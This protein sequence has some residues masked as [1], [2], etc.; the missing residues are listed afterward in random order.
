MYLLTIEFV[1]IN[2]CDMTIE[3]KLF[4]RKERAIEEM[5]EYKNKIYD[6]TVNR[7]N[8]KIIEEENIDDFSSIK[9]TEEGT[10]YFDKH[11]L[12]TVSKIECEDNEP[13]FSTQ[14]FLKS[15]IEM[16]MESYID[17]EPSEHKELIED[18]SR[19]AL[20]SDYLWDGFNSELLNIMRDDPRYVQLEKEYEEKVQPFE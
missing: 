3:T 18:I 14:D 17:G 16:I 12:I 9:F 7:R 11:L 5:N 1:E 8:M 6:Y 19:A 10:E 15:E 2:N 4:E 13:M 20:D